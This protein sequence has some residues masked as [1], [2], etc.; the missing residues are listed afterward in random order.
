MSAGTHTVTTSEAWTWVE[1]PVQGK[2]WVVLDPSPGTYGTQRTPPSQS[3]R[4]SPSPTP[5]LTPNGLV[6]QS[7]GNGH[8]VA[9]KS[10]VPHHHALSDLALTLIVVLCVL[11]ATAPRACS[12]WWRASGCGCAADAG[13]ATRAPA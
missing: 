5:T 6:T 11:L 13:R 10:R 8:A 2:G 12:A 4:P 3:A 7:P 9:P 1:I